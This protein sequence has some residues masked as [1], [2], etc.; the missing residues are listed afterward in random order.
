MI[1][2][3]NTIQISFLVLAFTVTA[4]FGQDK[5]PEALTFQSWKDEQV[6]HAQN[7]VLR[8]SA[9]LDQLKS[10]KS[11]VADAKNPHAPALPSNRI[12][13]AS[14]VDNVASGEKDVK[15]AQD[16]LQGANDLQFEDYINIYL[17]TLQDQP[18]LMNKLVE[19]LSKE[20]LA[21]IV[22]SFVKKGPKPNDTK[23]NGPALLE[24]LA[25]SAAS[26]AP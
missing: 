8:N 25:V 22:K 13:K 3:Q 19:K 10:G 17:P 5:A 6:L 9:R 24:G 2:L 1:W 26:K 11:Q 7:Q 16:I 21:E 4:A 14:T 15:R 12:K 20:E 18:E 23:H